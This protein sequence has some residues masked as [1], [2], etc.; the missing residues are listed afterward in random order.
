MDRVIISAPPI[1]INIACSI[2]AGV[3]LG[4]HG[5]IKFSNRA[6]IKA[7]IILENVLKIWQLQRRH[8]LS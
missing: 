1:G 7:V 3:L 5:N 8:V 6:D 2:F 4:E